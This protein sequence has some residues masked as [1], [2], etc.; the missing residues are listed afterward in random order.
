MPRTSRRLLLVVIACLGAISV[1]AAQAPQTVFKEGVDL[2]NVPVTV[3]DERG[4]FV[5]GLR[6]EDFTVFD[7]DQPQEIVS[8]DRDRVPVS[9]GILLDVSGSMSDEKMASARAA[10]NRFAYDLLGPQDE[11][12][13]AEFASA[14]QMLQTWTLDRDTFS[15][16]LDRTRRGRQWFGTALFDA[17]REVVPVAASGVHVRKALLVISDG[18][19]TRSRT[20]VKRLQGVIRSMEVL[21]YALGVDDEG[22]GNRYSHGVNSEALKAITE[23][24]GGRVEMVRGFNRLDQATARLA[25]ELNQQY[26]LRYVAPGLRDGSWHSI[27][28]QVRGRRL[29]VRARTGY[30]AS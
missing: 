26:M 27:R 12:F 3:T 6:K 7:G 20:P 16:A 11:L 19:D 23:E 21:V 2:I 8:F 10:I 4:R 1:V 13:L 30:V 25:D 29:T 17:V 9:L 18:Q 24:T 5:A 15:R 22:R 14:V 28:V